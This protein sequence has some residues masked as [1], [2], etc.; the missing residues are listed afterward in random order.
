M[1]AY[2]WIP[3][4]VALSSLAA[5]GVPIQSGAH[6]SPGFDASRPRTF[7]WRDERDRT[8]GDSRL[9]GNEYFHQRL[10]EAVGWELSLRGMRYSEEAPDLLVHHHLSLS[11]HVMEFEVIDDAGVSSMETDVYEGGSL[12]IHIVDARTGDDVW[13]AWGEANVEPA[14]HSPASMERWVYDLVGHMFEDW[15][16]PER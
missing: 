15:P 12:V 14:F 9:E 10:H 8:M 7:A 4:V 16:L 1:K 11:D 3:L 6:F 2:R 5:C 13:V